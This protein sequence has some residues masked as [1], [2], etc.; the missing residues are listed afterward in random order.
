[1]PKTKSD[2]PAE[3]KL[4]EVLMTLP[5]AGNVQYQEEWYVGTPKGSAKTGDLVRVHVAKT[6]S[7]RFATLT[8]KVGEV[9][10]SGVTYEAWASDE[11]A[12]ATA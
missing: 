12:L 10:R 7:M 4:R 5:Y 1:M 6:R 2:R 8:R 11:W 3:A 9:V